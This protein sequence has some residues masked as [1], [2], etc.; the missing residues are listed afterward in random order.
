MVALGSAAFTVTTLG[1]DGQVDP[2][3]IVQGIATGIGF[4]G[5]GSILRRNGEVE[6]LTTAAGIWVVGAI[7]VACG[8]G[9]YF[10]AVVAA[11][12]SALTLAFVGKLEAKI[13]PAPK[14]SE[15]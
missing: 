3:R 14:P 2:S 15:E 7:G 5:A 8:I 12:L 10:V 11:V 1:L 9:E 4:L 13:T 6:G